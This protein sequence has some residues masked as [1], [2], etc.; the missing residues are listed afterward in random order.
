MDLGKSSQS[1]NCIDV[2]TRKRS[3]IE[4]SLL[5]HIP[6]LVSSNDLIFLNIRV[7]LSLEN[8]GPNRRVDEKQ[9]LLVKP[10]DAGYWID[11]EIP[12]SIQ[13]QASSIFDAKAL[14]ALQKLD[15]V[16]KF[17]AK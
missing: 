17:L 16:V 2:D 1:V 15:S 8:I 14:F 10:S 7:R 13:K 9:I 6:I 3:L 4:R 11:S 5:E 12:S